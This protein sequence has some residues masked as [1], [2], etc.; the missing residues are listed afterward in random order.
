MRSRSAAGSPRS[1]DPTDR[2]ATTLALTDAGR[3]LL[4]K[5]EDVRG[6]AAERVLDVPGGA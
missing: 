6:Q 5:I 1:A 2:R 4:R 3:L